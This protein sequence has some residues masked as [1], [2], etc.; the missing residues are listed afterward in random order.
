M[1]SLKEFVKC[2]FPHSVP[3][4]H[5][6]IYQKNFVINTML[7]CIDTPVIILLYHRIANLETDPQ[8]LAVSIKNFEAQIHFLKEQYSILRFEDS[9]EKIDGPSIVITFDDGYADNYYNAL[10]ILEKYEVPAT[11]FIS[12]GNVDTEYEFWWDELERI[13][14]LNPNLP[15]TYT[16]KTDKE[17][18]LLR[19]FTKAEKEKSYL[20]VHA[21]LK[22]MQSE[23]R[24][25]FIEKIKYELPEAYKTRKF[26]RT[27][28]KNELRSINSSPFVT[29]G[30]H[31]ITHTQLSIQNLNVQNE[32][33]QQSK[34]FL[35]KMLGTE[36]TTFSYPFG[37][38]TDYTIKTV[39]AV[40][41]A[42]Y[43][44]A[45][46][47]YPGQIHT[48]FKKNYEYPRHL[49]RNWKLE[50]FKRKVKNFFIEG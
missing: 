2:K 5:N 25:E 12:T 28:K 10:P 15:K 36:V 33:I 26:Y 38:R 24:K 50:E 37:G 27:M 41:K 31:T 46:S 48:W 3:I 8:M 7:N 22:S 17:T 18:I 40:R 19:L 29:L 44:K 39:Q 14:L 23:E 13:F 16:L 34:K 4:Y 30:G 9:W 42:G 20:K 49:V 1:N 21:I 47:N 32:E 45:A 11:I 35:E 43:K 6:L